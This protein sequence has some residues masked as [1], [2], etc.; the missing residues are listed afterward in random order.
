ML[1]DVQI[2]K[3]KPAEKGY[4]L[5]DGAGL[6]L[7]VSPAGGK[8][9]RYRYEIGGKE[10]LLSLGA[11]PSVSLSDAREMAGRAKTALR[12][13]KDPALLKREQKLALRHDPSLT[14]QALAEEWHT[15]QKPQWAPIHAADVLRSLERDVFPSL[16]ARPLRDI[17]TPEVLEL[18]RGVEKRGSGETARRIRQR[19][20]AVFVY[21]IAT[22]RGETDPAGIVRGAMA[23]V[24]KRRQPAITDLAEARVM[25]QRVDETP[26]H[27]V[28]KLAIRLLA[29]TAVRP[30]T[31]AT[32][33]WYEFN[34][35]DAD[36]PI[37]Q[38]PSARMK[39]LKQFKDDEARDHLVPLSRQAIETIGALR[40]L[41]GRGPFVFPNGRHA[42]KP[43]SENAM[44]YMLN[45]AGYHQRHV[46]HGWR[47]TFS[48]VMNERNRADRPVID[49]M[50]A[51]VAKDR[52]EG[53]YNRAEHLERR[54]EIAQEWA[55]LIMVG[56][57]AP[58]D[59]LAL[60]RKILKRP[61][62]VSGARKGQAEGS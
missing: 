21:A 43:M 24:I 59:L 58:A 26:G 19:I 53:A 1:T 31:L 50:L 39:L 45:R 30:G 23:P 51:H 48:T 3:A 37:W 7:F 11:Y 28:T 8:L 5:T 34:A 27:P 33:P 6:H 40:A 2:R 18:L 41:T 35:L 47:S 56:Q 62:A 54:R 16:G 14:F 57:R 46:P 15:L 13:G 4:K 9:W 44:G 32:T 52:V 25:L 42:H 49:L 36:D 29:L 12:N 22:G 17:S 61:A 55:D 38:I 20:S 60:P 10:K